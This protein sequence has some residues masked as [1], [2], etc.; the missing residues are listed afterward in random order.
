MNKEKYEKRQKLELSFKSQVENMKK[1]HRT[2]HKQIL[3]N[4][5][6]ANIKELSELKKKMQ[7]NL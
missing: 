4:I 1:Y 6:N 7:M 2:R 5:K 3:K